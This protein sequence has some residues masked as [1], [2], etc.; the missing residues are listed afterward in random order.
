M[1]VCVTF[2]LRWAQ[3]TTPPSPP[4]LPSY[5]KAEDSELCPPPPRPQHGRPRTPAGVSSGPAS[6]RW[7]RRPQQE[8]E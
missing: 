2:L 5:L 3:K 6:M 1:C 7:A 8:K 4:C